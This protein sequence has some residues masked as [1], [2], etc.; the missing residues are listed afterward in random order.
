I[1]GRNN[2]AVKTTID[3]A[4]PCL[5]ITNGI[6]GSG[7]STFIE[8][9]QR[10]GGILNGAVVISTD[11]IRQELYGD[12]AKQIDHKRVFDTAYERTREALKQ[13]KPVVFDATSL[14]KEH[15]KLL[16]NIADETG[17]NKIVCVLDT[18]LE[19]AMARNADRARQVPA[20][21]L[22]RMTL[23]KE[24]LDWE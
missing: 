20:A 18:P 7:K 14:Y 11:A 8:G 21:V 19:T 9:Q 13:G 1:L 2:A 6:A 16:Y 24:A 4:K 3:P 5:F 15:R 10:P 23:Q 12:A 17:A 22:M